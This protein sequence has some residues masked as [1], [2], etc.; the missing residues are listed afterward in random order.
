ML[1]V[2]ASVVF[3]FLTDPGE[4][5]TWAAARL[6]GAARLHA[7]HLLDLE[8]LAALRNS[9]FRGEM[10]RRHAAA[11]VDDLVELPIKRYPPAPLVERIWQLRDR[12][13]PYDAVYVALAEALAL[14]LVTTD[15]RLARAGGHQAEIVAF[16]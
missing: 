5:G 11:A 9:V 3:D 6:S 2:D 12:L 1:V 7:P 10:S 4:R 14:P 13:T 8:V 15:G 16:A